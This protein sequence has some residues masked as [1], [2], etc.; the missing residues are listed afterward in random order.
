MD[1]LDKID[2]VLADVTCWCTWDTSWLP[3]THAEFGI[4]NQYPAHE[5]SPAWNL[6]EPSEGFV[7]WYG[8]EDSADS[9]A[10][11]INQP[12]LSGTYIVQALP[13]TMHGILIEVEHADQDAVLLR[14]VTRDPAGEPE[15][16]ELAFGKV[17]DLV[18]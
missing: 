18:G 4:A 2:A 8:S 3:L 6:P 15:I 13:W 12:D 1:V 7:S 5:P 10:D 11:D 17:A 16:T 9:T 14:S